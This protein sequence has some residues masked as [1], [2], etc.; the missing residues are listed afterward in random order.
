MNYF[1]IDWGMFFLIGGGIVFTLVVIGVII[2][3]SM[4]NK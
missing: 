3:L 2:V 1:A 4:K